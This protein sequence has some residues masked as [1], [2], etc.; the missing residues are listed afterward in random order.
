VVDDIYD[1]KEKNA[2]CNDDSDVEQ[3]NYYDDDDDDDDDR[4][5]VAPVSHKSDDVFLKY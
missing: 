2:N 3:K 4:K 1:D 5:H